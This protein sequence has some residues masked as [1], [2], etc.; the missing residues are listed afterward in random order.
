MAKVLVAHKDKTNE[1]TPF[2]TH[3]VVG[4]SIGASCGLLVNS[5]FGTESTF[6]P[7]FALGCAFGV[8]AGFAYN[9]YYS[10]QEVNKTGDVYN[11]SAE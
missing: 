1:P 2:E 7:A 10:D 4:T 3:L 11:V 9:Q 5:F 6:L 8:A